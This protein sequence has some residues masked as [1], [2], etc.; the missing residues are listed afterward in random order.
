MGF[1]SAIT[2]REAIREVQEGR[3][4]IPAF[5]RS[6]VWTPDKMQLLF[7]S[8]MRDYPI[9]S[10]LLWDLERSTVQKYAFFEFVRE[11]HAKNFRSGGMASL[12][13][14]DRL[15]GVL[16]GQQRLSALYIGLHGSHADR[17]KYGRHANP[18][19]WPRK[20]LF[21]NLR[22][23]AADDGSD[24]Q[25]RSRYQFRF[26]TELQARPTETA[27]WFPVGDAMG[28]VKPGD[29]NSYLVEHGLVGEPT[30]HDTLFQLRHAI[31]D[32][33]RISYYLE[34]VQDF[35]KVVTIFQ[36]LNKAGTPLTTADIVFSTAVEQWTGINAR[37]AIDDLITELNSHGRPDDFRFTRDFVLK[38]CLVL[39]DI[40]NIRFDAANFGA[41]NMTRIEAAWPGIAD[42]LRLTAKLIGSLGYS[43]ARL[44]SLNAA[45]P[46]AYYL[47]RKGT[48]K[49][50]VDHPTREADRAVMRRWLAG[51][52][53]RR[54]FSGHSD[55]KLTAARRAVR[56]HDANLF[57]AAEVNN[58]LSMAGVTDPG[59]EQL[60][61][62]TYGSPQGF[63]VLSLLYPNFPYE[64]AFDIDHVHPRS[65][66]TRTKLIQA[67]LTPEDAAYYIAHVNEIPNLQLLP[68]EQNNQKLNTPFESYLKRSHARD[69]ARRIF[70]EF[71]RIPATDLSTSNFRSFFEQRKTLLRTALQAA[72]TDS[73]TGRGSVTAASVDEQDRQS[74]EDG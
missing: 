1:E 32:E 3:W 7:D 28:F 34:K 10:F 60:L 66:A 8:L 25:D 30:T 50:F 74:V 72:L 42:A 64:R 73:A 53:V 26:L 2:I 49:N 47:H 17:I 61:A 45:I 58:R 39:A 16:D 36:R 27:F 20:R 68:H 65:F 62:A 23:V 38:S 54:V 67:G 63:A 22:H 37:Q 9:G 71:H 12:K 29:A 14:R 41:K 24:E 11:Y 55:N 51:V 4:V 40:A 18:A 48:P 52:L 21:L 13:G 6:L 31:W 70:L 35:H 44:T 15:R 59:I 69:D 56:D 19:A 57:P 46:L 5:Q 33:A 43:G